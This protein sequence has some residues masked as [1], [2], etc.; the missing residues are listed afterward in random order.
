VRLFPA[1]DSV[2]RQIR[3]GSADSHR[4][5][6]V[7]GVIPDT[8]FNDLHAAAAPVVYLAKAQ[9]HQLEWS[10][11]IIRTSAHAGDVDGEVRRRVAA[12]GR[13]DVTR[14]MGFE[15][16]RNVA[17]IRERLAASL[18]AAFGGL[19]MFLVA[20]ASYGLVSQSVARRTREL[21]LRLALGSSRADLARLVVSKAVRISV[22]GAAVGSACAWTAARVTATQLYGVTP[23]DPLVY[24]GATFVL[25]A[26]VA[27]ATLTPAW[28]ASRLSP[29]DA[30]R[31]D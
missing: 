31:V 13:E 12:H 28:R 22:I 17:L 8:H 29:L 5:V 16:A 6:T 9:E 23:H 26:V 24:A 2:G 20:V 4:A 3:V 27:G 30:L 1:G 7:I 14:I 11:V 19:A 15:T 25:I 10:S 18:G 21:G